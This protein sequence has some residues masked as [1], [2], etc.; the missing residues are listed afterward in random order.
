MKISKIVHVGLKT[1]KPKFKSGDKV[2]NSLGT[3]MFVEGIDEA[4]T[5][6]ASKLHYLLCDVKY[7]LQKSIKDTATPT[8][9]DELELFKGK[10]LY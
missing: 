1:Y 2:V 3:V 9:E 6:S 5:L 10:S 8:A 7:A 4:K